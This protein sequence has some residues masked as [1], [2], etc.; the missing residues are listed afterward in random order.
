MCSRYIVT[1][2]HEPHFTN[3]QNEW[4]I[5]VDCRSS[6]IFSFC[7]GLCL[8]GLFICLSLTA[9]NVILMHFSRSRFIFNAHNQRPLHIQMKKEEKN[10]YRMQIKCIIIENWKSCHVFEI[11][12]DWFELDLICVRMYVWEC[13]SFCFSI[14]IDFINKP[15]I[16]HN[17]DHF[18][19]EYLL[20]SVRTA[21]TIV[22]TMAF[23]LPSPKIKIIN[24]KNSNKFIIFIDFLLNMRLA[25]GAIHTL[26]TPFYTYKT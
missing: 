3:L 4:T 1:C 7:L 20:H 15:K 25:Y 26:I 19:N 13:V 10:E 5:V 21:Q 16:F 12:Y 8:F 23:F 18:T 22:K 6:P 14:Q 17:T 11:G 24:N 2:K 9:V